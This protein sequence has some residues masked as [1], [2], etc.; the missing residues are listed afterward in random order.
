MRDEWGGL[1]F[2]RTWKEDGVVK[3]V[4]FSV[5][6]STIYDIVTA[7]CDNVGAAA[8]WGQVVGRIGISL[9]RA[10]QAGDLKLFDAKFS[11]QQLQFQARPSKL[12][13]LLAGSSLVVVDFPALGKEQPACPKCGSNSDVQGHGYVFRAHGDGVQ[14]QFITSRRRLCTAG[15]AVRSACSVCVF[16][17]TH[18]A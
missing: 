15:E 6:G 10:L 13:A 11:F 3:K 14:T 8:E 5:A 7:N 4:S 1:A 9:A 18:C 12:Q 2:E 16:S 17:F